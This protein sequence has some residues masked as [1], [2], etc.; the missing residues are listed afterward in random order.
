[1]NRELSREKLRKKA[2]AVFPKPS[3]WD[4][5]SICMYL[6][7]RA[8]GRFVSLPIQKNLGRPRCRTKAPKTREAGDHPVC[9]R[10]AGVRP[11]EVFRP[12]VSCAGAK[13]LSGA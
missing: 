1:M 12:A 6:Y 5:N 7:V 11:G 3:A 4:G 2:A 13:R 9:G 8:R 10:R